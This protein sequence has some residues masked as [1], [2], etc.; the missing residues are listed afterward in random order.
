M[1][2]LYLAPETAYGVKDAAAV[3]QNIRQTGTTLGLS[4]DTL[5]SAELSA[6]RQIRSI[7]HGTRQVG[8]DISFEL[9]YGTHDALLEAVLCGTWTD[10][11][12]KAGVARRSFTAL[13]HFS[14]ITDLPWF[15]YLGVEM[16][17]LAMTMSANAIVTGTFGTIGQDQPVPTAA[18][19][20]GTLG[21]PTDSEVMDSFTGQMTLAGEQIALA[22]E[23]TLNLDNGLATRFVI[24]SDKT[25][26][27]GIKRS[28]LTGQATM[29][30][31]SAAV[32]DRFI[33][34]QTVDLSFITKDP[35]GNQYLW[36]L[37][38]I[39]FT[40]GQPDISGEDD[41][42]LTMPFSAIYDEDSDSQIVI[43]RTP[44]E[45]GE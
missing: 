28:T 36:N 27:P 14:D 1:H 24:G 34:E 38:K 30:F 44:V 42:V 8:G 23:V 11:V 10:N 43:T 19:P 41:I 33:T 45:T 32:I 13:R 17:T 5:T 2:T 25:L 31:E 37:P 9:S 21:D 35:A 12:L 29:Y 20:A 18:Q 22:T 39:K 7:R 6:D 26:R 4:K 16:N 3:F 40:G 15:Q